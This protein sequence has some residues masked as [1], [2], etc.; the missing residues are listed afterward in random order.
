LLHWLTRNHNEGDFF[1]KIPDFRFDAQGKVK[2]SQ[3]VKDEQEMVNSKVKMTEE[4]KKKVGFG[5]RGLVIVA[6]VIL[7]L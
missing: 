7:E 6:M 5:R 3:L 4:L 1:Q 2:S